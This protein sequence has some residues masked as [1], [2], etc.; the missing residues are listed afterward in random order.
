MGHRQAQLTWATPAHA[1]TA[2]DCLHGADAEEP[3]RP[4]LPLRLSYDLLVRYRQ[5]VLD[6][7]GARPA[8]LLN[9][10]D[11]TFR[12]TPPS[13]DITASKGM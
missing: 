13:T 5:G 9:S 12:S 7:A 6:E 3:R 8:R 11:V 2:W 4:T 10:S 1:L